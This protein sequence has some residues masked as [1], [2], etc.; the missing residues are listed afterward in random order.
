MFCTSAFFVAL[1]IQMLNRSSG[2][3]LVANWSQSRSRCLEV[4]VGAHALAACVPASRVSSPR[5][6][7]VDAGGAPKDIRFAGL[8][9]TQQ[10]SALH[11]PLTTLHVIN[12]Q[13]HLPDAFKYIL[14]CNVSHKLKLLDC[15]TPTELENLDLRNKDLD[16]H[17][18]FLGYVKLVGPLGI[19]TIL[20][21]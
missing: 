13:H 5:P 1:H 18:E 3:L 9:Y 11:T 8:I 4:D 14:I 10:A 16:L 21:Y 20:E 6:N 7:K 17:K 2:R 15:K 12:V 19:M